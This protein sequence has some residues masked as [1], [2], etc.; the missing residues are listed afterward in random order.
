MGV[1]LSD[2][3]FQLTPSNGVQ[4]KWKV[5]NIWYKEDKIGGEAIAE[6]I[7]SKFILASGFSNVVNYSLGEN[8]LE[9]CI[10]KSFVNEDISEEFLN[11]NRLCEKFYGKYKDNLMYEAYGKTIDSS[12][13]HFSKLMS[14]AT[15]IELDE[16]IEYLNL[17]LYLDTLFANT[18]RHT[19]NFGVVFSPKGSKIFRLAP[20]F[21]FGWSFLIG[22]GSTYKNIDDIKEVFNKGVYKMAPFG[23]SLKDLRAY[24]KNYVFKIDIDMFFNTLDP[25]V[26]ETF[27]FN[28]ACYM[29]LNGNPSKDF[30]IEFNKKLNNF[31]IGSSNTLKYSVNKK[32]LDLVIKDI[33]YKKEQLQSSS[34]AAYLGYCLSNGLN[35]TSY[36]RKYILE[37]LENGV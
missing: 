33:K 5:G 12:I 31:K 34:N 20:L 25:R 11:F 4:T 28:L 10:S 8:K 22:E 7:V 27:V 14:D 16:I 26:S 30:Q 36:E 19:R 13:S 9:L 23:N 18:D 24:F 3:N 35:F 21:D 32:N 29:I 2:K 1:F 15:G 6:H 37:Q 17:M